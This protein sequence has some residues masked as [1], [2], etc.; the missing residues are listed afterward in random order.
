MNDLADVTES[1]PKARGRNSKSFFSI[2]STAFCGMCVS[3][4]RI[5]FQICSP[6]RNIVVHLSCVC[7]FCFGLINCFSYAV[8]ASLATQIRISPIY[9]LR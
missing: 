5:F 1:D 6:V 3:L 9:F 4:A 8:F 2:R 7:L